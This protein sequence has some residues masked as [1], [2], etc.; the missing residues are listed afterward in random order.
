MPDQTIFDILLPYV[1]SPLTLAGMII[2]ATF[3]LEDGATISAGLLAVD[4]LLDPTIALTALIVGIILG[5]LGLYG[6]GRLASTHPGARALIGESRLEKGRAWLARRLPLALIG[7][8]CMPGMRTPTYS[9]S[10][11]LKVS[12]KQFAII[13]IIAAS[14]WSTVLFFLILKF[15][16]LFA[17]MIGDWIWVGGLAVVTVTILVPRILIR[18]GQAR[19]SNE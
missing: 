19:G 12:F 11:F 18:L 14:I 17:E 2:I 16:T 9:A 8:R 5:D 6:L 13:A 1:G 4:G 3:I 7:A 10:G 15:G